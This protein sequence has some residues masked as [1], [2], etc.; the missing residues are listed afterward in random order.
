MNKSKQFS[1]GG[2]NALI[3]NKSILPQSNNYYHVQL[4][5]LYLFIIYRLN[6][7]ELLNFAS[8][9]LSKYFF[10]NTN[11]HPFIIPKIL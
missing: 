10:I 8:K 11:F 5:K 9:H 1:K 2:T 4:F 7:V 3:V 6:N